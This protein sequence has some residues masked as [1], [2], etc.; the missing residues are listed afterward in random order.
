MSSGEEVRYDQYQKYGPFGH[1]GDDVGG[2]ALSVYSALSQPAPSSLSLNGKPLVWGENDFRIFENVQELE[3]GI[4]FIEPHPDMDGGDIGNL[5]RAFFRWHVALPLSEAER[6]WIFDPLD[7]DFA[8]K[9]R[10]HFPESIIGFTG[11]V[12]SGG[13]KQ[14][15]Q[16]QEIVRRMSAW[17]RETDEF[18]G[19]GSLEEARQAL[20]D[21]AITLV[22]EARWPE[23]HSDIRAKLLDH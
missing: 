23:E 20:G 22:T 16:G 17:R 6:L 14:A 12:I 18:V 3:T 8:R 5:H 13:I 15:L 2:R 7:G 11:E 1:H 4:R 19:Q 10:M 9:E 21:I